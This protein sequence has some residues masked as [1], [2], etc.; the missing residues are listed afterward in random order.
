[1]YNIWIVGCTGAVWVEMIRCLELLDIS[2]WEL[3]LGASKRSAGK[4]ESTPFGEIIIRE[5]DD[6]FFDGL[7]F[8]LFSAWWDHSKHYAPIAISKGVIVID[9]SSAFRYDEGVPLVIPQVNGGSIGDARLIA[10]PNCTTAIAAIVLYPIYQQ[11]GLKKILM[12]TY[13][14][15]SGAWAKGMAELLEN[16]HR[17]INKEE[18][19]IEYF[20]HDIAFNLIPHIDRFLENGYTKEEMKVVWETHKIFG[21]SN[22]DISCTAVRIP[23][24]RAHS[25]T[26]VL[27]TIEKVDIDEVKRILHN[28]PWVQVVDDIENNQYPM[29]IHASG[30]FEVEVGRIRKNL[31][32]GDYG[33]ELFISGDQLLR[34]AA[35]NAVEILEYIIIHRT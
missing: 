35:L 8:A 11:F 18:A 22:I 15:T 24:L 25:E 28:T 3:R 23:T 21:D 7:D 27:E 26:I 10:N 12:S 9:N 29:P 14:A 17:Y 16:T 4:I 2:V 19:R 20:A 34:G 6:D 31:V 32:F 5:V 1:M 33:I 13:Q 30:K